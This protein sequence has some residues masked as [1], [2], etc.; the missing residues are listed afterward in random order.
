MMKLHKSLIIIVLVSAFSFA[1]GQS[2]ELLLDKIDFNDTTLIE[3]GFMWETIAEY[4]T[5]AQ[6]SD[7]DPKNQ[8]Y[9]LILAA[10]NVLGRSVTSYQ[11]YVAVYQYLLSGFSELGANAIVDYLVRMPY[12]ESLNA[13]EEQRNS[14]ISIAESYERVKIGLQSPEIQCIT[15]FDKEFDLYDIDKKYTIILFWSYSCPHCRDLISELGRLTSEKNDVAIV[16]VNV[17]G[18]F[19]QVKKLLKKA[20]LKKQYNVCDGKG[21]NS[22]IVEDYAVN[23]TPSLFLLD[24][25]KIIISKPFDLEEITNSVEL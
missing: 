22:E 2:D 5:Q 11:M 4:I 17:S 25:D 3:G 23:M 8:M 12:L 18:D 20:G 15:V 16:T 10:D 21:W 9:N 6:E 24:K 19:K 14:I 7:A 1:K 13:N